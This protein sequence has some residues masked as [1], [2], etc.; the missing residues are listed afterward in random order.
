[1]ET[2]DERSKAT[3]HYEE[4][5]EVHYRTRDLRRA[6][7]MYGGIMATHGKAP[8]VGYACSQIQNIV[9]SVVPKQDLLDVH[10]AL[11]LSRLHDADRPDEA[12]APVAGP[13]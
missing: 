9:N 4:A 1:M 5:Y 7:E 3:R 2:R 8:E 13:E 12:Q 10:V 11:A 6:L